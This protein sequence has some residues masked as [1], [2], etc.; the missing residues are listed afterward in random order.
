M[1]ASGKTVRDLAGLFLRL[2]L[3]ETWQELV[4]VNDMAVKLGAINAGMLAHQLAVNRHRHHAGA[5][6]AGRINHDRVQAG[7][8]LHSVGFGHVAHGPPLMMRAVSDM[9][10]P[11]AVKT[12]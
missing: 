5:A 6:H 7:D 11:Y 3:V 4:P 12:V 10:K 8:R 1:M 9:T 2:E